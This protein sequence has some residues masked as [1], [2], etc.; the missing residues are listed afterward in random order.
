MS[1]VGRQPIVIPAGVDVAVTD[2]TVRVKGP[3]GALER[4]VHPDIAV[5][6]ADAPGSPAG[7]GRRIT[8]SRPTDDRFHRALH[9]LTRALIANMVRGVTQGYEV[10]LEIQ[11][12]GYRAQK[13]G[14]KLSLQLGFSHPVELDPPD[15]I[16]LDAPAPNRIVVSGIDKEAVGQMAAGIRA[17]RKPDPYKGKGVRYA[18][19]RVRRKAG[20]AGKAAA[21]AGGA[22][23]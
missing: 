4:T 15:G 22:K 8:V 3:K 13:Q 10:Q 16:T 19:E 20:K 12:V 9:G 14:K 7:A 1:R 11:G 17:L 18:G 6:V 2:R 23:A 5:A 21:G